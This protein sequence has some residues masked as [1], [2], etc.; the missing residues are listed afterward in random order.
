MDLSQETRTPIRIKPIRIVHLNC[1]KSTN[2]MTTCLDAVRLTADI[3]LLQE[4]WVHRESGGTVSNDSF[5]MLSAWTSQNNR[6]RVIT[7]V[8]CASTHF[9]LRQRTDILQ[10]QDA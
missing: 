7:Y 2:V 10:D 1:N 3:V 6:P 4:P 8:N 5:R 9:V